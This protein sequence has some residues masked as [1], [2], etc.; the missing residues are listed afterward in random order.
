MI[1]LKLIFPLDYVVLL[2]SVLFILFS[3]WKG[4]IHSILALMTWVGSII[5]TLYTYSAF[6]NFLNKQLLNINIF[7][8][9]EI[10]SELLSVI[11]AIPIIFLISLFILK[12]IRK[13]LSSDLDKQILGILI[14]KILGIVYGVFFSYLIFSTILF[15]LESLELKNLNMW[16]ISNSNILL[17]IN[18]INHEY[19]YSYIPSNLSNE[20][21]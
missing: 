14:D 5:I 17:S 4:F 21:I 7:Q 10:I 3:A 16:F 19:I 12:R 1:A 18:N 2:I 11:I 13:V 8:N 6:S 20:K 9:Y 15:T